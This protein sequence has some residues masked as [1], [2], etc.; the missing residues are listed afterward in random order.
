[1]VNGELVPLP[2]ATVN[3]SFLDLSLIIPSGSDGAFETLMVIPPNSVGIHPIT[4]TLISYA[5]HDIDSDIINGI[6]FSASVDARIELSPPEFP[7]EII[8]IAVSIVAAVIG[9]F[10]FQRWRLSNAEKT[11]KMKLTKKELD[12]L[13]IIKILIA[14]G[15]IK[16]AIAYLYI[17]YIDL[18]ALKYD[19]ERK[20]SQTFRDFAIMM[21]KEYGQNP[22][23]IYPFMLQIEKVVYG[24]FP[25]SQ[26]TFTQ[27]KPVFEKLYME[28][29]GRNLTLEF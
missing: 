10:I 28:T 18:S 9:V 4:V 20:P 25:T 11:D 14:S 5:G 6:E 17:I 12:R 7:Y 29:T 8:I 21:V 23:I 19:I 27:I 2:S 24:G 13:D 1:L 16:E 15:R 26:E 3:I 22:Q